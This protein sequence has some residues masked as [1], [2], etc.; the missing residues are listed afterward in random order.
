MPRKRRSKAEPRPTIWRVPDELWYRIE[1]Y[2]LFV[3]R[4]DV[5]YDGALQAGRH[6][7]SGTAVLVK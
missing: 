4:L 3:R 6:V 2:D 5:R 1:V 7:E